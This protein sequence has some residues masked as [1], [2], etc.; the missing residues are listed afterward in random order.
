MVWT[1]GAT[2]MEQIEV[3]TLPSTAIFEDEL[4]L[5]C[6][7]AE[8]GRVPVKVDV[9]PSLVILD[10]W[11]DTYTEN[12]QNSSQKIGLTKLLGPASFS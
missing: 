4:F 6:F 2:I 5:C 7:R 8:I 10:C 1:P 11:A 9:A 12:I 3:M